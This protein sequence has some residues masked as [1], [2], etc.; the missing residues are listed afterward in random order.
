MTV[1]H[2]GETGANGTQVHIVGA[3]VHAKK[4]VLEEIWVVDE[5]GKLIHYV[6]SNWRILVNSNEEPRIFW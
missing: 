6:R 4:D 1:G 5:V 2:I 3:G